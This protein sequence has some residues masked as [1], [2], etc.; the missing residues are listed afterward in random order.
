MQQEAD[1]PW[2]R[3][4]TPCPPS[5][6]RL[7]CFPHV[8]GAASAYLALSRAL[9][10]HV[11]V[12]ALQ[13]PA[14]QDRRHEPHPGSV[15]G[16][17]DGV[18]GALSTVLDDRPYAF[19]GHSMGALLA[20]ETARRTAAAGVRGPVRLFAS[21]RR[22]PSVPRAE[23]VHLRD[24]AGL[25]AEIRRLSGTDRQV[26]EDEELLALAL[27]TIRAD[28]R[29]VETY[30]Y[31][32][33][34]PLDC[35]VTVFAGDRD[36]ETD[37]PDLVAEWAGLTTADTDL[38]VFAGGHFYLDGRAEEVAAEITGRLRTAG[39]DRSPV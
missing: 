25:L 5:A 17:A 9:A 18:A 2:V 23:A 13:Y 30:R 29:A 21:A 38:R 39:A 36:T 33:A 16:L 8:G 31:V 19:F 15:P 37:T 14:R 4:F 26:L 3:R 6:P 32:P 22:A 34:A 35:P 11:E 24:D 10:P 27:P 7:I 20:F 1:N 12:L 28:Y